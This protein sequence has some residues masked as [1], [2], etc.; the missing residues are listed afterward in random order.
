MYILVYIYAYTKLYRLLSGLSTPG[1]R[2][3]TPLSEV[4]LRGVRYT[5]RNAGVL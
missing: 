1:S 4:H 5:P 2:L 3:T